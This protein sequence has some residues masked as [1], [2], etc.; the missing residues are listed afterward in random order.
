MKRLMPAFALAALA[1]AP[2]ASDAQECTKVTKPLDRWESM[3]LEIESDIEPDPPAFPV[4]RIERKIDGSF[5]KGLFK[6][7]PSRPPSLA[8]SICPPSSPPTL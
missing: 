1:I 6:C 5:T 3:L 8:P 7:P 2:C 4:A